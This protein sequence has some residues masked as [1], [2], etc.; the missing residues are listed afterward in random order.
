[1]LCR[2]GFSNSVFLTDFCVQLRNLTPFAC[3]KA[4]TLFLFLLAILMPS[5]WQSLGGADAQ[6][7]LLPSLQEGTVLL[8]LTLKS[9]F[10]CLLVL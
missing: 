3:Q 2:I 10:Y 4:L 6:F 7:G 5:I 9:F 8:Y 1:M